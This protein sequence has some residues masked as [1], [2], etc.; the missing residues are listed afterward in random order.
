M[1][2]VM[3]GHRPSAAPTMRLRWGWS[4]DLASVSPSFDFD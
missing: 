4:F 3:A 2:S 1:A